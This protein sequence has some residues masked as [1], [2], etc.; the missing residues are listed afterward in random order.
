MYGTYLHKYS[1]VFSKVNQLDVW[2]DIVGYIR[3][4]ELITNPFRFD[5]HP[6]CYLRDWNGVILL[7][8]F[9]Y[10]EYNKYTCVHAISKLHGIGLNQA[11]QLIMNKYYYK[12][13]VEINKVDITKSNIVKR[14]SKTSDI[15]FEPYSDE[16][17]ACFI[18]RDKLYWSK[19]GITSEQLRKH[20]VYSVKYLFLN[21]SILRTV[22]PTYAYYFLNGNV[23][24]YSPFDPNHKW[25]SNT[26]K[27]DV[28]MSSLYPLSNVCIITKSLK[29]LMV[30]ENITDLDIYAFQNEG[31]VP[32]LTIYSQYDHC[33]ILF[34]ND[35]AGKIASRKISNKLTNSTSIFIPEDSGC[36]DADEYYIQYGKEQLQLTFEQLLI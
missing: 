17:G 11:A 30:L 24:I 35:S 1:D 13:S 2:R 22:K 14:T 18:E 12:Q 19:R 21:G 9:A 6:S 15:H 8:D 7:T 27:E 28:W 23:K 5:K 32:D 34:D 36:K 33:Y 3:V 4:G 31:V 20:N 16:N 10:P 26:T 25:V 29:D